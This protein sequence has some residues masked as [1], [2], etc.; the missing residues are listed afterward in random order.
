MS[1]SGSHPEPQRLVVVSNRLPVR[2]SRD[3][4]TGEWQVTGSSGG[5]VTAMAPVLE[6]RGGVWIGWPGTVAEERVELDRL[7]PAASQDLGYELQPVELTEQERDDFYLGFSNEV[8]WPLFHDLLTLYNF[9]P[10]YWNTYRAVN[11]K[12][13]E[14]IVRHARPDDYVWV[15]DYHLMGVAWFLREMGF[16]GRV[17]F[18]L[19][20][21]FPAPDI[22]LKL[23]WRSEILEGLLRYDLVG[24]QTLRDRRNFLHC[25]RTLLADVPVA[26]AGAVVTCRVDGREIRVGSFP[27]S[28]DFA[29][30]E[31]LSRSEDVVT[32]AHEVREQLPGRRFILGVDRL[33]YTKGIPYRL[34]AFHRAINRYPELRRVVSLLQVVVPSREDIPEYHDLKEEIERMVGRINGEWTESGW[35]PIHYIYRSLPRP[36]LVARYRSSEVALVTPL[37]DGMNLVA[38]EFCAAHVDD[39]GV[40]ILSEF[41]G[42]ADQLQV[43]ALL[44][45]PYDIEGMAESIHR[46][47]TMPGEERARRMRHLRE[48][49]RG[50]DIFWWVALFLRA[51]LEEPLGE[52]PELDVYSPRR[53]AASSG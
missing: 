5:L 19:H 22:Y 4:S 6:R 12:Y 44:V 15:H 35:V 43:G 47:C 7:L 33:D 52:F 13:A 31:R 17:G 9:D 14:V 16:E 41:A 2:L 45:N 27:I 36:D 46:A 49:V 38:K 11:R 39:E 30:F 29:E 8:V 1:H 48:V 34:E 32:R 51:A 37:K 28:I 23:P 26:G 18:F 53:S 50:Q 25:V 3:S 42:A 40:L 24:F 21:P 10:A 20:T